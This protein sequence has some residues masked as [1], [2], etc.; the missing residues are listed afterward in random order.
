MDAALVSFRRNV[1]LAFADHETAA[2][3]PGLWFL[4]D[5]Q[6]AGR[7]GRGTRDSKKFPK[8]RPGIEI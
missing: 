4:A 3:R 2:L 7:R 8:D 6:T 1:A 5:S